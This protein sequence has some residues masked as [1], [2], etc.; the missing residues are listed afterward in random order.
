MSEPFV[1]QLRTRGGVIDLASPG[2]P[3][4]TVRVEMPEVW[5][6]VRVRVSPDER[7]LLMKLRALEAL[8]PGSEP[9]EEYVL[10][11][12]GWEVLDEHATVASTG[13]GDGSIFLL[14]HR[15]RRAVR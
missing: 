5:D 4:I 1:N 6:V 2:G 9:H 7:I 12:Y 11:L 3:A 13:A 8:N 15:R 10:K 14:T